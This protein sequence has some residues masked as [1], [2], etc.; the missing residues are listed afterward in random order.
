MKV[1]FAFPFL[2]ASL[3]RSIARST[4]K[5]APLVALLAAGTAEANDISVTDAL[6][7]SQRR[8]RER[9]RTWDGG[10]ERWR[11]AGCACA[12]FVSG[13][14]LLR[15]APD[16]YRREREV[17]ERGSRHSNRPEIKSDPEPRGL[18]R[19]AF[20]DPPKARGG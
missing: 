13:C 14:E 6:D 17:G 4:L 1:D 12:R 15:E 18:S 2:S 8:D 5:L 3:T 11:A 20:A 7:A 10:N 9:R 19:R 16:R